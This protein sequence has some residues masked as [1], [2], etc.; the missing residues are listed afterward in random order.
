MDA[1]LFKRLA[2]S[3]LRPRHLPVPLAVYRAHA[4]TKSS[5]MQE[6][7]LAETK[8]WGRTQP[9]HTYWRW[10]LSGAIDRVRRKLQD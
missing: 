8:D 2:A 7:A 5:R 3:G 6:I 4:E 9:W 1:D 10:R